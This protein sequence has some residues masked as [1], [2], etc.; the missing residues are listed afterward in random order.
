M[1]KKNEEVL[2]QMEIIKNENEKIVQKNNKKI[3]EMGK[4][5]PVHK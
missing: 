3:E 2:S 5:G 4:K 1:E